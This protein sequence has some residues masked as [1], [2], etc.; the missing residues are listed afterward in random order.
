MSTHNRSIRDGDRRFL[1]FWPSA[2][3]GPVTHTT[4]MKSL[5]VAKGVRTS[6]R[7]WQVGPQRTRPRDNFNAWNYV[8]GIYD[9]DNGPSL[10]LVDD[11]RKFRHEFGAD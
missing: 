1:L 5:S 9:T 6:M 2:Q 11:D 10:K 8:G 7:S 4:I 3:G